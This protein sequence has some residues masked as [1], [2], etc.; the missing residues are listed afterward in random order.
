MNVSIKSPFKKSFPAPFFDIF[1]ESG[2]TA[3]VDRPYMLYFLYFYHI[4]HQENEVNAIKC[5]NSVCRLWLIY[6]YNAYDYKRLYFLFPTTYTAK[7]KNLCNK[8]FLI[9][10]ENLFAS[11]ILYHPFNIHKTL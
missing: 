6:F 9:V 2:L 10:I 4:V 1:A 11:I 3:S 8:L 5:E 7:L